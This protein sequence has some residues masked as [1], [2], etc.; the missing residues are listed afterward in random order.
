MDSFFFSPFIDHVIN[1]ITSTFIVEVWEVFWLLYNFFW[2]IYVSKQVIFVFK[3]YFGFILA[4]KN[5]NNIHS[6]LTS[7]SVSLSCSFMILCWLEKVECSDLTCSWGRNMTLNH[8]P[9][10]VD[11]FPSEYKFGVCSYIS[12]VPSQWLYIG[13]SILFPYEIK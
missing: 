6:L 13:Q 12:Y 1:I 7:S 5:F 8:I 2:L 10:I 3:W 11:S 9:N 4:S